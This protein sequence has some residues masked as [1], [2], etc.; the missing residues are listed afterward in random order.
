MKKNCIIINE[1]PVDNTRFA[2][3]PVVLREK[4]KMQPAVTDLAI[5]CWSLLGIVE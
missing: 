5:R 4:G 3:M 1:L 2:I